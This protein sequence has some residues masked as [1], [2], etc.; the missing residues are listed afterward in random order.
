VGEEFLD[1]LGLGLDA[2]ASAVFNEVGISWGA[3]VPN[4]QGAAVL[5]RRILPPRTADGVEGRIEQC[6]EAGGAGEVRGV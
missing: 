5:D 3:Q 6:D 1:V 2:V 4:E